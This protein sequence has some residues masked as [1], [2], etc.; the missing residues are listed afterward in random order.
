MPKVKLVFATGWNY[1]KTRSEENEVAFGL[2][3]AL[4]WGH[5]KEDLASFKI[6]TEG[7]V[8]LMGANTFK[9]LP[10][11]LKGRLHVVMSSSTQGL[12]TR[13]GS[14]PDTVIHGGSISNAVSFL[15]GLY[16]DQDISIIGGK[17]IILEAL[18]EKLPDEIYFNIIYPTNYRDMQKDTIDFEFDV[19]IVE[20]DLLFDGYACYSNSNTC[21]THP[22]VESFTQEKW[23]KLHETV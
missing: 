3:N 21:V 10:A 8:L 18:K 9:S 1:S 7:S 22:K 2:N 6:N 5:L 11:K 20:D 16:P 19:G 4:P 12:K 17:G 23:K 13:D 14:A 15:Q